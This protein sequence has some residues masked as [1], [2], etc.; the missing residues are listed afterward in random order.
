MC[1]VKQL[2]IFDDDEYRFIEY[3]FDDDD[4][5]WLY[6][7]RDFSHPGKFT[8]NKEEIPKLIEA[9]KKVYGS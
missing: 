1:N 3:E 6:D 9:L 4:V 5:V 8:L 7:D 2:V